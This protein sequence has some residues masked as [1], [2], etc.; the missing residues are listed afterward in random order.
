M[1]K[2]VN[3]NRSDRHILLNVACKL[4][5][6]AGNQIMQ[7]YQ[8]EII[9]KKKVDSSPVTKADELADSLIFKGLASRTPEIPIISE[10]RVSNGK[11]PD[12]H[13]NVFWLVDPLDGTKEFITR[14]DEFTVNIAL[15]E[16][17]VPV[18]G[19]LLAPALN[20]CYFTDGYGAYMIDG[21]GPKIGISARR[22][23]ADEPI[24]VASRNHRD[25]KTNE[26]ISQKKGGRVVSVGSA[27]KFALLAKGAADLYPR[28]G[29]TM[30]WDVAA[31]HAILS[32][33]GGG[34]RQPDSGNALSYGKA[35]LYNPHF[36]AHGIE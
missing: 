2:I 31:G 17:N 12:I 7:L 3:I 4:A 24:I 5:K 23:P 11:T 32:A 14:T 1:K 15:I 9:I 13:G 22:M 20:E 25:K 21:D 18:L 26:F 35:T 19:V 6:D 36:I 10:E 28:F 16:S 33:A 8:K 34:I 29:T 30:E 27:L